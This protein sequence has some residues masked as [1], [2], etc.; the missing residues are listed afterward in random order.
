[1]AEERSP[2]LL[3]GSGTPVIPANFKLSSLSS[4]PVGD[5]ARVN[6]SKIIFIFD[7][8]G[9]LVSADGTPIESAM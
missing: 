1:M 2:T 4:S 6:T 3:N 8:I 5:S 9:T 7:L